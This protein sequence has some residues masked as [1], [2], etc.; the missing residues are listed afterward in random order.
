MFYFYCLVWF[1]CCL[2]CC[3]LFFNGGGGWGGGGGEGGVVGEVWRLGI[4]NFV[5]APLLNCFIHELCKSLRCY[6]MNGKSY[7]LL[8][9][10]K[11][12]FQ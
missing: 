5:H 3:L 7:S 8:F 11:P 6:S 12:Q 9:N 4:L 2:F 10:Q 1:C